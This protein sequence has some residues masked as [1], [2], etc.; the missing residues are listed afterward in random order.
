MEKVLRVSKHSSS[1][2]RPSHNTFSTS[3]RL[4]F[5]TLSRYVSIYLVFF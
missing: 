1:V 4:T 3:D 2:N 5:F